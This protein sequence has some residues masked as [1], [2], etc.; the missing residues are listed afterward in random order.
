MWLIQGQTAHPIKPKPIQIL[1]ERYHVVSKTHE[2]MKP[3]R[4]VWKRKEDQFRV[5]V[6]M[7]M[8]AMRHKKW[9]KP[10]VRKFVRNASVSFL[11]VLIVFP[12]CSITSRI[13]FVL[14]PF[15]LVA[16]I[17]LG[18]SKSPNGYEK[19]R[20]W[21]VRQV[22]KQT[23]FRKCIFSWLNTNNSLQGHCVKSVSSSVTII[24]NVCV[25]SF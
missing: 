12:N 9:G 22:K 5:F 13:Q 18:V 8:L 14:T 4:N 25:D 6:M 19:R 10:K 11:I 3:K 20:M 1:T 15:Q 24:N 21:E 2:G 7:V 17:K 23:F 16:D